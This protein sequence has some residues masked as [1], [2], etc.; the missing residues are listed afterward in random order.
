MYAW[1]CQRLPPPAAEIMVAL[2]YLLLVLLIAACA[3]LPSA[4]FRYLNW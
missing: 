1:L 2:W 4:E 3:G